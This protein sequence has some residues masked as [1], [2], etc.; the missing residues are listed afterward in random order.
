MPRRV[1]L[2]HEQPSPPSS[3]LARRYPVAVSDSS[4]PFGQ[5]KYQVRFDWGID[6]ARRVAPGADVVVLVD[7]LGLTTAAVLA[8][9]RGDALPLDEPAASAIDRLGLGGA[10]VLAASLRNRTA[11]AERILALQEKRG[12]RTIVAVVALGNTDG[13][14]GTGGDSDGGDAGRGIRFGIA[15]QLTAGAVV[16]ALI[17]LGIDHTS[18]EAAVACAAYEGLRNAVVHLIGAS[19]R[20]AELTAAGR[21]GDVRLATERDVARVVPELRDRAFRA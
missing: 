16:D 7:A 12:R 1:V 19:G 18:P 17:A 3:V 21:R 2:R 11:V 10:V 5:G 4:A 6:G 14:D 9:E 20:G 15:D 8:A 13:G